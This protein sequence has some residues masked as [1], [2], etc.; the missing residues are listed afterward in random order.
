M[1]NVHHFRAGFRVPRKERVRFRDFQKLAV[2]RLH[3][4]RVNRQ[5]ESETAAGV[6][7][8]LVDFWQLDEIRRDSDFELSA[9]FIPLFASV[10]SLPQQDEAEDGPLFRQPCLFRKEKAGLSLSPEGESGQGPGAS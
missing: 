10:F 4:G 6:V 1:S 3:V 2:F 8:G 7:A 9:V 5:K